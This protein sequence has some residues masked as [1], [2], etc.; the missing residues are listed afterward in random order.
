MSSVILTSLTLLIARLEKSQDP[1]NADSSLFKMEFEND[2]VQVKRALRS[3]LPPGDKSNACSGSSRPKRRVLQSHLSQRNFIR[4]T[5]WDEGGGGGVPD[6]LSD[7]PFELI[8]IVPKEHAKAG[9]PL[10]QWSAK[11]NPNLRF[12]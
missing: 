11:G 10:M 8:G 5:F 1:L 3:P 4:T 2:Q 7:K 9:R 12:Q 6:N